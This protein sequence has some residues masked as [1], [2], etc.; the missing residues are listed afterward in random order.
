MFL[1]DEGL[2]V[3]PALP[4][5][6]ARLSLATP[7]WARMRYIIRPQCR[8]PLETRPILCATDDSG[9]APGSRSRTLSRRGLR[10]RTPS[11]CWCFADSYPGESSRIACTS[12]QVGELAS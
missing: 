6:D 11:V 4:Q 2:A 7:T 10:W 12:L 8:L 3:V 5:A 9:R 1:G